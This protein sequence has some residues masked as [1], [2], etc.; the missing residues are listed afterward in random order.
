MLDRNCRAVL[1]HP[2]PLVS[3]V[4]YGNPQ[5]NE[6]IMRAWRRTLDRLGLAGEPE[7]MLIDRLRAR[8][9]QGLPGGSESE[10]LALAL[11]DAPEWLTRAARLGRHGEHGGEGHDRKPLS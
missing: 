10:K 8:V 2:I 6:P 11:A 7:A 1:D 9:I 5:P 4:L 3:V